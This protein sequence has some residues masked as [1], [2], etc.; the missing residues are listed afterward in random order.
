MKTI[1]MTCGLM[2]LLMLGSA[3]AQ[4]A[5]PAS[6]EIPN[7]SGDINVVW[8]DPLPGTRGEPSISYKLVDSDGQS[9]TSNRRR[10]SR[11][12]WGYRRIL[13]TP[14]LIWWPKLSPDGRRRFWCGSHHAYKQGPA[15]PLMGSQPYIWVRLKFSDDDTEPRDRG[16]YLVQALGDYP[17]MNHYWNQVSY[18]NID[19]LGKQCDHH[20]DRLTA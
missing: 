6:T 2:V 11:T 13:R 5:S 17:S 12:K 19:L 9:G 1:I 7:L 8:S 15:S 10:G 3:L 14:G 4:E 20:L 18:Q 16:W